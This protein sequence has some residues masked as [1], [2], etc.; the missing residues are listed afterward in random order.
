MYVG[1]CWVK[2]KSTGFSL[3]PTARKE[4]DI[5]M[6]AN[7]V[8]IRAIETWNAGQIIATSHDPF[9]PNGWLSKGNPLDFTEIR[10]GQN[11][12]WMEMVISNHFPASKDQI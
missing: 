1:R 7:K 10:V 2:S 3:L 8:R 6:Y 9:P 11:G 5:A 12:S 4:K